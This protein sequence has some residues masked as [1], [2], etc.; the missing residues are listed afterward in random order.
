[1]KRKMTNIHTTS[2]QSPS[3][4]QIQFGEQAEFI[5]W[6]V[7]SS[8]DEQEGLLS[9][10]VKAHGPIEL[11]LF[12]CKRLGIFSA[13]LS[14]IP[15]PEDFLSFL[16]FS[17]LF[18]FSFSFSF[19]SV[20]TLS[21]TSAIFLLSPSAWGICQNWKGSEKEKKEEEDFYLLSSTST[22]IQTTRPILP[23]K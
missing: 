13:N 8:V 11:K 23:S 12:V 9:G 21:L 22:S 14:K 16:F 10:L 20:P 2:C 17:F 7:I 3:T 5:P 19:F 15:M 4:F 6:H 1:M 18:S